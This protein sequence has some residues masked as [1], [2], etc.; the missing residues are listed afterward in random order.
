LRQ[1][2]LVLQYVLLVGYLRAGAVEVFK[3]ASCS[4]SLWFT[5]ELLTIAGSSDSLWSTD[6]LIADSAAV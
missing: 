2:S 6:G 4:G 1:S 5:C 3:T